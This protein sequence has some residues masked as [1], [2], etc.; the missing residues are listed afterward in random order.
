MSHRPGIDGAPPPR[1]SEASALGT[2]EASSPR[3]AWAPSHGITSASSPG[4][5]EAPTLGS[6]DA[7]S[8]GVTGKPFPGVAEAAVS[9]IDIKSS[10]GVAGASLSGVARASSPGVVG[11]SMPGFAEVTSPGIGGS[12]SSAS[13]G[14]A[15]AAW[16][17]RATRAS[18]R[19]LTP[20][21][22]IPATMPWPPPVEGGSHADAS[23][24][25]IA[26]TPRSRTCGFYTRRQINTFDLH[27][28]RIPRKANLYV[29]FVFLNREPIKFTR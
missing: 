1:I 28:L 13:P 24:G 21:P 25:A 19:V 16:E 4:I 14:D 8:P 12:T 5:T 3:A 9:G 23:G 11:A 7:S 26:G 29:F 17:L 10:S 15:P 27:G 6:V 20:K 22:R 18:T 2:T